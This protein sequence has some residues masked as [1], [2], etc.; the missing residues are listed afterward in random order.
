MWYL[1]NLWNCLLH[2]PAAYGYSEFDNIVRFLGEE[3]GVGASFSVSSG[4]SYG[5]LTLSSYAV[6]LIKLIR[7][8]FGSRLHA[9]RDQLHILTSDGLFVFD[10]FKDRE[11]F[12]RIIGLP[13]A[14]SS[15]R[16]TAP[17]CFKISGSCLRV[18]ELSLREYQYGN[19]DAPALSIWELGDYDQ[20]TWRLA[21]KVSLLDIFW[22]HVPPIINTKTAV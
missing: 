10:P 1:D 16:G 6:V 18:A 13:R 3:K 12:S 17:H 2:T 8:V 9:Y 20:G 22:D 4:G 5:S 15:P 7:V 21:F 11:K 19:P 14:G